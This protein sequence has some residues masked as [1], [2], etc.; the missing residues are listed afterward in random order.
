MTV[1]SFFSLLTKSFI[2]PGFENISTW[3]RGLYLF[4]MYIACIVF[5]VSTLAAHQIQQ[6]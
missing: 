1:K 5:V 6:L 3:L 4:A 2:Q